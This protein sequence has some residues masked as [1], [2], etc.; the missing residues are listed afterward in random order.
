MTAIMT[1]SAPLSLQVYERQQRLAAQGR[2]DDPA[3]RMT[4]TRTPSNAPIMAHIEKESSK[5][6][7]EHGKYLSIELRDPTRVYTALD[8]IIGS[9]SFKDVALGARKVRPSKPYT[10]L[11]LA[12][13]VLIVS[14][15]GVQHVS[16]QT[17]NVQKNCY[18]PKQ[19][20]WVFLRQAQSVPLVDVEDHA[21]FA[22][23]LPA[24]L[25]PHQCPLGDLNHL[26]LSPSCGDVSDFGKAVAAGPHATQ[27]V[28]MI[29]AELKHYG[30]I[31]CM[32][33]QKFTFFPSGFHRPDPRWIDTMQ[34]RH[35]SATID[36]VARPVENAIGKR[37]GELK[38]RVLCATLTTTNDDT[39]ST[40]P[41]TLLLTYTG[42]KP[43]SIEK[44]RL[45]LFATTVKRTEHRHTNDGSPEH[46]N[47]TVKELGAFTLDAA[48]SRSQ[49][50]RAAPKP[51]V[52][53]AMSCI[54]VLSDEQAVANTRWHKTTSNPT[55]SS[56]LRE[57]GLSF[58]T[59]RTITRSSGS[60]GE[61][62]EPSPTWRMRCTIPVSL[63]SGERIVPSFE[64]CLVARRY[65]VQVLFHLAGYQTVMF[66]VPVWICR[67]GA[68]QGMAGRCADR[69][70][71]G[72]GEEVLE[73]EDA[74]GE[75]IVPTETR[76]LEV[77]DYDGNLDDTGS[78]E[79][80]PTY[81][82]V[83]AQ[84]SPAAPISSTPTYTLPQ[85]LWEWQVRAVWEDKADGA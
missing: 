71:S 59:T 37:A 82:H 65:R 33:R 63:P 19:T 17:W 27:I 41:L 22:F 35:D 40:S 11:D 43:P 68:P 61:A 67:R 24:M 55:K 81:A 84:L 83:Q 18:A 45:N 26:S 49:W 44:I 9:V 54:S 8:H 64:S 23:E 58:S 39:A 73:E 38:Y 34:A 52:G 48:L 2:T 28:Y 62:K 5:I 53:R 7:D 47:T 85:D 70:L 21:P 57:R 4:P 60:S 66:M 69:F 32:A 80:A 74:E 30:S 50:T 72:R 14:L 56:S 77:L 42:A 79:A 75:A 46:T 36:P 16:Y 10:P 31:F 78:Q 51:S 1:G 25:Q 15:L 29:K 12:D 3:A 6:V 76:R 13:K 20:E